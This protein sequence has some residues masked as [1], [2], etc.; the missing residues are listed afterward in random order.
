MKPPI[1][2]FTLFFCSFSCLN[3]AF[4]CVQDKQAE[5]DEK[6]TLCS[7]FDSPVLNAEGWE[8]G[9]CLVRD[10]VV[11]DNVEIKSDGSSSGIFIDKRSHVRT[12]FDYAGNRFA[13]YEFTTVS[14]TDFDLSLIH[15]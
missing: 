12:A 8:N 4:C 9:D 6:K 11:V 1:A 14:Y 7:I 15:I 13:S 3:I 2:I 5:V 10:R